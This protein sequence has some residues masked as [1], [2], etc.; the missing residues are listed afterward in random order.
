[1]R[2]SPTILLLVLLSSAAAAQQPVGT[3]WE[4]I[5]RVFQQKGE[6]E[7]GYFRVEFPRADLQVRIADD[8]LS[9]DFEFTSY[10]AFAPVG[11]SNVFVMGE[12]VLR[13]GEVSGAVAEA[14]RAGVTVTAV[15][16]HLIGEQ[17]RIV[18]MH[19][20]AN[21][22]PDAIATKLRAILAK[23]STPLQHR[24]EPKGDARWASGIDAV[25]GGHSESKGDVVAYEFKRLDSHVVQG[26]AVKSSGMLE[27][28][29]EAAFERVGNNRV[30]TTGELYVSA[31]EAEGV[32]SALEEHGLHV[33]ALHMHMLDEKPKMMYWIHWYSTGDGATMARGVLAALQQMNSSRKSESD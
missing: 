1:M 4:P 31:G 23:T 24:E 21:G 25:L 16:N 30:A 22:A 13:E 27:T 9:P 12:V 6:A 14:R 28:A 32:L 19:V 26:V 7:D 29:S 15:H 3:R 2:W 8:R 5:R 33:T 20:T 10:F 11:P 17:P 18:Y